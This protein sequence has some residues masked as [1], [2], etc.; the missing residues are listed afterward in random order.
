ML[1]CII[2]CQHNYSWYRNSVMVPFRKITKH[3]W[4]YS[5]TWNK[6]QVFL[7]QSSWKVT[8]WLLQCWCQVKSNQNGSVHFKKDIHYTGLIA[9]F[10]PQFFF[11]FFFRNREK[12]PQFQLYHLR[13]SIYRNMSTMSVNIVMLQLC[14]NKHG[15]VSLLLC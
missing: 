4:F 14:Y 6:L 5:G 11:F 7:H 2:H 10:S 3:W 12:S 9:K 8:I 1:S 15:N 13:R